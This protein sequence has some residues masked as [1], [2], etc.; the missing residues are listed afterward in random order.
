MYW[1]HRPRW[2]DGT[3]FAGR[4]VQSAQKKTLGGGG[5]LRGS[6]RT[7]CSP[8]VWLRMGAKPVHANAGGMQPICTCV[9][10]ACQ[11]A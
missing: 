3:N 4:G 8:C 6:A 5:S 7:A 1:R 2:A 10:A 11:A 9:H